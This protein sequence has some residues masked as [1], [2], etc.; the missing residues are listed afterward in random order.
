M[1]VFKFVILENDHFKSEDDNYNL[2]VRV[3]WKGQVRYISTKEF[4]KSDQIEKS[5]GWVK[6]HNREKSIV[7]WQ[8][9]TLS[10]FMEQFNNLKDAVDEMNC[11]Q[12]KEYLELEKQ[13]DSVSFYSFAKLVVN[14]HRDKGSD[15]YADLF[16]TT[17][18]SMKN[19]DKNPILTFAHINHSWLKR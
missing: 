12:L 14:E 5:T 19:F 7:A 10:E 2:K 1:A 6:N 17:I 16:E 18:K 15:G 3:S 11:Q 13:N 8:L 4:I 9:R